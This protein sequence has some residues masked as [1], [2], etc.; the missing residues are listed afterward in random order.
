[1]ERGESERAPFRCLLE[2]KGALSLSHRPRHFRRA[3]L[4]YGHGG[5]PQRE[6]GER[7]REGEYRVSPPPSF[8]T[9]SHRIPARPAVPDSE[10]RATPPPLL[11]GP[12]PPRPRLQRPRAP[13]PPDR[14]G[15]SGS[16]AGPVRAGNARAG[17]G[18]AGRTEVS[19][20]S[21]LKVRRQKGSQEPT[22]SMRGRFRAAATRTSTTRGRSPPGGGAGGAAAFGDGDGEEAA[23]A[24]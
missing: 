10:S 9:P 1:M 8:P 4:R 15:R 14:T 6:E 21:P 19:R 20:G 11:S 3:E 7:E 18:R 12:H 5:R 22:V 13:P 16:R 23:R 2:R 17:P 24:G